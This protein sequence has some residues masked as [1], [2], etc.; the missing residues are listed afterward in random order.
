MSTAPTPAQK[1][2]DC[3]LLA[4]FEIDNIP[5]EYRQYYAA[6][7]NNFFASV[8]NWPDRSLTTM[9]LASNSTMDSDVCGTSSW[10]TRSC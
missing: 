9:T 8:Q 3:D 6:K 2:R 5:E 4:K 1:V 7:R 10:C